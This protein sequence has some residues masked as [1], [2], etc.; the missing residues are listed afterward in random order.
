MKKD[1]HPKYYPEAKVT[2]AC[3]NTFTTGSTQPELK[4]EVCYKCH[5]FY[6]G[7]ERLIDTAGQLEKFEKK[8]EK[9]KVQIEAKEKKEKEQKAKEKERETRPRTLRELLGKK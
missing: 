6:T 4:V 5:P 3:G 7:K 8:R 9:A 2:C 1:L